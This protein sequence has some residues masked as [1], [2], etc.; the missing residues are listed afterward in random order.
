[1]LHRH[2][3]NMLAHRCQSWCFV[4]LFGTL[5]LPILQFLQTSL[6]YERQAI[7]SGEWW[8]LLSGNLV[9]TNGW[10]LAL[11]LAGLWILALFAPQGRAN[12][13]MMLLILWLMGCVGG[14]LWL[15][16]PQL[17]WYAGLSGVL[18]GLFLWA[19]VQLLLQ[20]DWLMA[21]LILLGICGKTLWDAYD[22]AGHPTTAALI[23]APVIYHAHLYG[24]VGALPWIGWELWHKWQQS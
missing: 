17:Q 9:H 21:A 10:H 6:L 20:R 12:H 3:I 5:L 19:G 13:H 4:A 24:M 18:Y 16:Q 23:H 14:G 8:R 15:L 2:A 11:N 7:A 22:G 1:M